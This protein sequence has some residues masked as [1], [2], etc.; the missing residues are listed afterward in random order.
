MS[1]VPIDSQPR[2]QSPTA[3][4]ELSGIIFKSILNVEATFSQFTLHVVKQREHTD[5]G[6]DATHCPA[7]VGSTGHKPVT[8]VHEHANE[9]AAV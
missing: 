1:T 9:H 3:G 8:L 6:D 5:V 4:G 2:E 7:M